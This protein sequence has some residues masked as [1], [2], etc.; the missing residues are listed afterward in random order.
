MSRMFKVGDKVRAFLDANIAGNIVEIR[1]MPVSHWM[2][3]GAAS[4][5]FV[6]D[7]RTKTGKIYKIKLGEL[8]H[9]DV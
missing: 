1:S 7:V 8:M 5:E 2:S 6:A 3:E 9:D 4:V